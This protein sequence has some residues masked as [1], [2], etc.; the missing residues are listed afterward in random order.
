MGQRIDPADRKPKI[1]VEFPGDTECMGL[2]PE[3]K[4]ARIAIVIACRVANVEGNKIVLGESRASE[5]F[6]IDAD[7]AND[8]RV[9]AVGGNCNNPHRLVEERARKNLSLPNH[10]HPELPQSL[11]WL[12]SVFDMLLAGLK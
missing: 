5:F 4:Q 1:G 7:N 12:Q 6:G 9:G 8:P 3:T 11:N 2:K 10:I